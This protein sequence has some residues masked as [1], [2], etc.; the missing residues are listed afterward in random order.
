[1]ASMVNH[2][3]KLC[4]LHFQKTAG[5]WISK[6]LKDEGFEIIDIKK[7][8]GHLGVTSMPLGYQ[9]FGFVR[10]P[11]SWYQS[12]FNYLSTIGWKLHGHDFQDLKCNNINGF[13]EKTQEHKKFVLID[14]YKNF[15]AVGTESESENILRYENIY[16]EMIKISRKFS[17]RIE[18]K[19]RDTK[20]LFVN[21]S[22][23]FEDTLS[24]S[25]LN[26]I[27]CSCDEIFDRFEYSRTQFYR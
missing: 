16:D 15:F 5:W 3:Q 18:Q 14:M 1:M 7:Y 13:I 6:I 21:K 11:V 2:D 12:L 10:H 19:V 27:F 8:G 25:S 17:L 4:F 22:D 24:L 20:D 9:S 23:R 26:Y